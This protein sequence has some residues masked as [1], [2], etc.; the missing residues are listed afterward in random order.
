LAEKI[1]ESGSLHATLI[2]KPS[3][4]QDQLSEY[5]RTFG[6]EGQSQDGQGA[7]SEVKNSSREGY[8][9]ERPPVP[10]DPT[11][12]GEMREEFILEVRFFSPTSYICAEH[13]LP[14]DL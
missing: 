13:L 12:I 9:V 11:G 14:S 5:L 8:L 6:I 7:L 10:D 2:W 3:M 1:D 4:D